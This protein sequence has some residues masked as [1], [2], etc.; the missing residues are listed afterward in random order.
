ML[1]LNLFSFPGQAQSKMPIFGTGEDFADPVAQFAEVGVGQPVTASY[2]QHGAHA[3]ECPLHG[4]SVLMTQDLFIGANPE[5]YGFRLLIKAMQ[6][7][8]PFVVAPQYA[9][10]LGAIPPCHG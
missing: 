4:L 7:Y 9:L 3:G 5:N 1:R 6:V 8:D 2:E 10:D